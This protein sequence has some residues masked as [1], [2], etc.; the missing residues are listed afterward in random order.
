MREYIIRG[1]NLRN[2]KRHLMN[3]V[4]KQVMKIHFL[5]LMNGYKIAI[6]IQEEQLQRV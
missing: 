3:F 6:Q 1:S 2:S 5:L 4:R